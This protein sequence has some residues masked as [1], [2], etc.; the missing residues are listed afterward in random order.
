MTLES[1]VHQEPTASILRVDLIA[2][3]PTVFMFLS[4]NQLQSV[5]AKMPAH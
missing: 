4:I 1:N 2:L 3:Y 5:I